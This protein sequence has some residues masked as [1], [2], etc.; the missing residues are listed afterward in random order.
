MI[1]LPRLR[2][3]QGAPYSHLVITYL[4]PN[5]PLLYLYY[6]LYL[7]R[8]VVD[9]VDRGHRTTQT[10][11]LHDYR[12]AFVRDVAYGL[13]VAARPVLHMRRLSG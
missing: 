13:K 5:L 1:C 7:P 8:K 2:V 6:Y 11:D 4:Y 12:Q 3:C 9:I 10:R